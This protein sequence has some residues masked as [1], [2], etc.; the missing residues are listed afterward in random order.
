MRLWVME[1]GL[2]D[3][4][5]HHFNNSLGLRQACLQRGIETRFLVH[6]EAPPKV[7]EALEAQAIF[8]HVPYEEAS[9]DPLAGPLESLF[10]QGKA[11]ADGFDA[12]VGEGLGPEDL[13]FVPTTMQH[14]LYGC[15]L[16]LSRLA[17]ERRPRLI[18]NFMIENFLVPGTMDLGWHACLY[19]FAIRELA[20]VAHAKNVLLTANGKRMAEF[21]GAAL[22]QPVAEYPMPKHYPFGA[23]DMAEPVS[24][25][26]PPCVAIL[27]HSL[28]TK[29]FHLIPGL[30]ARNPQWRWLVQVAPAGQDALWQDARETMHAAQN[31]ELAIGSLDP[32][33]YYAL[34]SRADVIL[35]PYDAAQLPL[36]SSGIFSE[37]VAT[38]KVVVV[39][40]GTWMAEHLAAGRG[41]G[42]VF[43]NQTADSISNALNEAWERL[44]E[45]KS[46]AL[47]G[48][49]LWRSQQ[50]IAAYLDRALDAL[51]VKPPQRVATVTTASGHS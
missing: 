16:G 38:G 31:V 7:I 47:A 17:P 43:G 6:R 12:A 27:G 30:V 5:G 25:Q 22:A 3:E 10:I 23:A 33:A 9:R 35:L 41:S 49:P 15:A 44:P 1:N 14:E 20:R 42:T 40:Q 34:I 50:C 18:L 36:R 45:L 51:A 19:R 11:F 29:G 26:T 13:V 46:H 24:P 8:R 39:P 21:L 4:T 28:P 32:A 2:I 48:A 37:A